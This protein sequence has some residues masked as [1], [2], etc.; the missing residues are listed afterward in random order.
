MSAGDRDGDHNVADLQE[1]I[2]ARTADRAAIVDGGR[3]LTWEQ[4]TERTR[5]LA[6]VLGDAGIG[7]RPT[8]P[9]SGSRVPRW[10]SPHDHVALYLYNG[11]PYLEGMFGAWKARAAAVNVNYRYVAGELAHLLGDARARALIVDREF[12]PTVAEVAAD[13]PELALV[14][15]VTRASE[16][17]AGRPDAVPGSDQNTDHSTHHDPAQDAVAAARV[18]LARHVSCVDYETALADAAPTAPDGLSPDD[19]YILYTGG[20]TGNPKG[21]L[22][23]Q[24]DFLASC[25][26]ISGSAE[27]LVA[28][29]AR[30]ERSNLRALP[31]APLMHGAA[32]WNAISALMAGGTVVIPD[33][34]TRLNP[35]DVLTTCQDQQ[36][37]SLQIVGDAFA[38]PLLD[39]LNRQPYDLSQLTVLLSGGAVLSAPVK[40]AWVQA[41]PGLRIIDVLGSS[42]TGRQ[43]LGSG[44]TTG[45]TPETQATVLS[46][47][48]SRQLAAGDDEVGWLAQG[49]RVPL[50]YLGDPAKT[51]A[52]FP[53]V[54]GVRYA[55]AGDRVRLDAQGR[56]EL[57]GRDA[58]V[59]N[60]GGEKVY[61]EEVEQALTSH[62]AVA[63]ALVV[64]VDHP[65]W[66]QQVTAVAQRVTAPAPGVAPGLDVSGEQLREHARNHLAAYKVPKAVI[67]VEAVQRSPSGKPDYSWARQV[68]ADAAQAQLAPA[69]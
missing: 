48:L 5:R 61:A 13:L 14:L 56:I 33:D 63:D 40:Q 29:A 34:P 15:V 46:G 69:E 45:F 24:G 19:R 59:I 35:V 18:E 65:R 62:P 17:A 58:A 37:T 23:R 51:A 2:A 3:V 49:G 50:G 67:W 8:P 53:E 54:E 42:E 66:G 12:L 1:R 47:D 28:A 20:T 60:T 43:A 55:V 52:T 16:Q 36:V 22:W 4:L 32:H 6:A 21:V 31:S 68:A 10:S 26:G 57:L 41:V 30:P 25:L 39:E 44:T 27:D 11:H 38:R 64:G 9:G 7:L